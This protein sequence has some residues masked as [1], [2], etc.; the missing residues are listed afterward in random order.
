M[1]LT[2]TEIAAHVNNP[3]IKDKVKGAI[4]IVAAEIPSESPLPTN[5]PARL[6][7]A[8]QVQ[9]DPESEA[10]RWVPEILA[11]NKDETDIAAVEGLADSIYLQQ[12]RDNW[13]LFI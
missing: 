9:S 11:L 5:H 8:S 10:K 1:A 3:T 4:I 6:A 2:H 13:D 12:A 7:Y